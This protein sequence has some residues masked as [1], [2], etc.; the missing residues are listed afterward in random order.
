MWCGRCLATNTRWVA[1]IAW[2]G[3]A[4]AAV[5]S[6]AWHPNY[7]SY[8]NVARDEIWMQMTDSNID[9]GQ[10]MKQIAR[11]LDAHPQPRGRDV[12][13]VT[14]TMYIGY[15]GHYHLGDRVRFLERGKSAPTHGL[16]II[17]PIWVCGVYDIDQWRPYEFLR[18]RRPVAM[19]GECTLVYD[20]DEEP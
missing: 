2:I 9:Y 17:S 10:S 1:V 6:I 11:W 20:L 13:V 14:R 15:D 18:S 19:I 3:V 12:H 16:L 5:H 7:L 4:A 8:V